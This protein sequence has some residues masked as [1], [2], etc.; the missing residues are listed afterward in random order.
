MRETFSDLAATLAEF[1]GLECPAG[2]SFLDSLE[3]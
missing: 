3:R 1:F 2:D